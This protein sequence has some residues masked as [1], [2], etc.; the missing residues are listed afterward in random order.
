MEWAKTTSRRDEKYS[1]FGIWCGLYERL[2]GNGR[3]QDSPFFD[4][5]NAFKCVMPVTEFIFIESNRLYLL[6]TPI[7][8]EEGFRTAK[9]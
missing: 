6:Q 4:F 2:D 1:S 3:I 5:D 9:L 7:P 8:E